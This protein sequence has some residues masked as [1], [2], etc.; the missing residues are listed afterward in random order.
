LPV[1]E[2]QDGDSLA[3]G[4]VYVCPGGNHLQISQSG[5]LVLRD[6]PRKNGYLPCADISMISAAEFAGPMTVGVVLTGMGN[7]G[8][9]GAIAIRQAG[10]SVVVQDESSSVI[11]GMNA[12]VIK[13][14]AADAGVSLDEIVSAVEKRVLYLQGACKVGAL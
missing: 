14:S 1:K 11:F 4:K 10:G 12:E 3:A 6:G 8:V 13:A 7:D 2:A 9:E 5:R